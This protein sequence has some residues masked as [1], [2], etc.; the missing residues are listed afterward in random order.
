MFTLPL[1]LQVLR[2]M[3]SFCW[4]CYLCWQHLV[5][6]TGRTGIFMLMVSFSLLQSPLG[7]IFV[8]LLT[9]I[10]VS[11]LVYSSMLHPNLLHMFPFMYIRY[12][13]FV[14]FVTIKPSFVH[15]QVHIS[16]TDH[17]RVFF[18]ATGVAFSTKPMSHLL[19]FHACPPLHPL[20][21]LHFSRPI[22]CFHRLVIKLLCQ[23]TNI[24]KSNRNQLQTSGQLEKIAV[25][26]KPGKTKCREVKKSVAWEDKLL[27]Q[28]K[29]DMPQS[30][31]LAKSIQS[32]WLSV[33]QWQYS[34]SDGNT[35]LQGYM[36][37][38]LV[39]MCVVQTVSM[40]VIIAFIL[41][42][43]ERTKWWLH[44]KMVK[45]YCLDPG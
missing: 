27:V 11:L 40:C 26:S 8:N 25:I 24:S 22:L 35:I 32:L 39:N 29:S 2:L 34:N 45:F 42:L 37:A 21:C 38:V 13:F 10:S 3:A 36:V 1:L 4:W 44:F 23:H 41:M 12:L 43:T 20:P 28:S 31:D 16:L 18:I 6:V 33:Q 5:S 14:L 19:S 17:W 30:E 7:D 15:L 9:C